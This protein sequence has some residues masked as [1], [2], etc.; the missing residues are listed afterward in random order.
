M[1]SIFYLSSVSKEYY[2]PQAL[3]GYV[4]GLQ[5]NNITNAADALG[6]SA[7]A[8]AGAMAEENKAVRR[9]NHR[10]LRR[11]VVRTTLFKFIYLPQAI[12]L[13][14]QDHRSQVGYAVRTILFYRQ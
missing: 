14:A 5:Q 1:T 3:I 7:A 11:I 4:K 12:K 13:I 2:S 8:I 9:N 6:V 10:A